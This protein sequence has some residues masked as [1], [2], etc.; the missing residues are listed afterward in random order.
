MNNKINITKEQLKKL[1][2]L[3]YWVADVYYIRERYGAGD[4]E[5][6]KAHQNVLYTFKEL[7]EIKTPFIVQNMVICFAEN[8]RQYKTT[9]TRDYLT[10]R[11]VTITG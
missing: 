10:G 9:H 4:P 6:E 8:W 1:E 11:G 2:G 7:D 3:A 5:H